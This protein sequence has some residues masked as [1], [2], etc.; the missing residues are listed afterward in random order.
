MQVLRIEKHSLKTG[1]TEAAALIG[2]ARAI[3]EQKGN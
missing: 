1:E 2:Q 3:F